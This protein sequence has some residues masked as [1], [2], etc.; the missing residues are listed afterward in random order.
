ME[1]GEELLKSTRVLV[2]PEMFVDRCCR[3]A[4]EALEGAAHAQVD[5]RMVCER[6]CFN[7]GNL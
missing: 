5:S 2:M 4:W 3:H 1:G 6:E 7:I